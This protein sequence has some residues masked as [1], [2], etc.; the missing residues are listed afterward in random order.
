MASP[1]HLLYEVR[2]GERFGRAPVSRR[3]HHDPVVTVH[4]DDVRRAGRSALGDRV[5]RHGTPETVL[6]RQLDGVLL[7][8]VDESSFG[9]DP[10]IVEQHVDDHSRAFVL[11]LKVRRVDENQLFRFQS[12]FHVLPEN[13]RFI[14]CV[15]VEPD[16]ADAKHVG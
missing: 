13:L 2:H 16:F 6:L 11:I 15:L 1:A 7:N 14:L 5:Q 10:R 8:V 3:V 9:L 12:Q 4:L